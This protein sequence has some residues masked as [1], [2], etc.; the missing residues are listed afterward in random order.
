MIDSYLCYWFC[1]YF[2]QNLMGRLSPLTPRFQQSW[3]LQFYS[4]Y[5]FNLGFQGGGLLALLWFSKSNLKRTLT[6][7][8]VIWLLQNLQIFYR[9]YF[10]GG[11]ALPYLFLLKCTQFIWVWYPM[12]EE[13]N[14]RYLCQIETKKKY[15]FF[16]IWKFKGYLT[17][18]LRQH[19]K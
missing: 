17:A 19:L 16:L 14:K 6:F 18:R 13:W 11:I 8:S 3:I 10:V 4:W 12:I 7:C 2:C 5:R 9:L 15:N 1:F